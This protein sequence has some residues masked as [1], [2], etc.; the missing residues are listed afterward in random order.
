MSDCN[1]TRRTERRD[2]KELN[3]SWIL[4]SLSWG[5]RASM[6]TLSSTIPM[7]SISWEGPIVLEDTTGALRDK[8]TRKRV[9]KVAQ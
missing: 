8:N 6:R 5:K 7:N 9:L 2:L 4:E 3:K 1:S